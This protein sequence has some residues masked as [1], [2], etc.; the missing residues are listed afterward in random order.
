MLAFLER[1]TTGEVLLNNGNY[2][3]SVIEKRRQMAC[4]AE[5]FTI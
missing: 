1:P 5:N 3:K 2:H 4:Y